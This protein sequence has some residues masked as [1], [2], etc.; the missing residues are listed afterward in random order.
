MRSGARLDPRTAAYDAAST[1]AALKTHPWRWT[2]AP[3]VAAFRGLRDSARTEAVQGTSGGTER[4]TADAA[5]ADS[6]VL[7]DAVGRGAH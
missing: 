5:D 2:E 6:L 7:G 4:A 3:L 1:G